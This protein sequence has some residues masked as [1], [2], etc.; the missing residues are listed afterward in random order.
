M[1]KHY[2]IFFYFHSADGSPLF[3]KKNTP[4]KYT[5]TDCLIWAEAM[6]TNFS[7]KLYWN[8]LSF[9]SQPQESPFG[10]CYATHHTQHWNVTKLL[11]RRW[12]LLHLKNPIVLGSLD[13]WVY[14]MKEAEVITRK[15]RN[16]R[17]FAFQAN[18][19][20]KKYFSESQQ[21]LEIHH[22]STARIYEITFVSLLVKFVAT[23]QRG[24]VLWKDWW[25]Y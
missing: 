17:S 21:S 22:K 2:W 16:F 20:K 10:R 8:P 14:L 6:Q 23:T 9:S 4:E 12:H 1:C 25:C 15:K 19:K 5:Q 24:S 18:K 3:K 11:L 7:K 13:N